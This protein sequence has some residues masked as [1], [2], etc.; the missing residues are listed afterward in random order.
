MYSTY[1]KVCQKNYISHNNDVHNADIPKRFKKDLFLD[2]NE[3][4]TEEEFKSKIKT[5]NEFAKL[6]GI[7]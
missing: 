3:L 1:L 2:L 6:W 5:N 4:L 7:N